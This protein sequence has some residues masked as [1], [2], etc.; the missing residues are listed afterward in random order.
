MIVHKRL[1]KSRIHPG[2]GLFSGDGK[3]QIVG[4]TS[5]RL[6]DIEQM[7][8]CFKV[9]PDYRKYLRFIWHE[10]NCFEKPLVDYQMKV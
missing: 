7:L 1:L 6:A 5:I 4:D 3:S 10:D 9:I 8:Y 2:Y